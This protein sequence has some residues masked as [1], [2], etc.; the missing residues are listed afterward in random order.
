V[1]R[2]GYGLMMLAGGCL[3]GYAAYHAIR[4]LL[5]IPEIPPF[6]KAVILLAAFGILLT[7][8][9]LIWERRKEERD[10]PIDDGGHRGP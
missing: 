1:L 4:A 6:L 5:S 7:L 9:G 2:V 8:G 10:A 3:V